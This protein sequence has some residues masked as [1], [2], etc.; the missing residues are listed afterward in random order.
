MGLKGRE[1]EAED[2]GEAYLRLRNGGPR[3]QR[4]IHLCEGG[5]WY[6]E[7]T[8]A[9]LTSLMS[10]WVEQ[11]AGR[12]MSPEKNDHRLLEAEA[13][14]GLSRYPSTCPRA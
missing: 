1:L 2:I 8:Q 12:K 9:G 11:V 14:S 5:A 13:L 4:G 7:V 3:R 10:P 6:C